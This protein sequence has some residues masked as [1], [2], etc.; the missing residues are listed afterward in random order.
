MS[1]FEKWW[2]ESGASIHANHAESLPAEQAAKFTAHF[3]YIQGM[4]DAKQS[5]L[6]TLE[7]E[8]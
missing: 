1:A 4:E 8:K 6:K 7:G 2:Q 3:A 5:L